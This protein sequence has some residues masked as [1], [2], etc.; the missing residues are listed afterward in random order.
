MKQDWDKYYQRNAGREP[1]K[2]L[3]EAVSFCQEKESALDLGAGMLIEARYLL[4]NGFEKVVAID[5]SVQFR[6]MS[7]K[8]A[9]KG[10]EMHAASFH[11]LRLDENKYD[12]ISAQFSLPF[13]GPAG[14]PGFVKMIIGSLKPGGIFTGQLFGTHDSWNVPG[15]NLVFH[16]K[17]QVAELLSDLQILKL[18]EVE[19]DSVTTKVKNKHWHVYH[20]IARK[21]KRH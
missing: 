10:L 13:Y 19:R 1:R 2:L 4:E 8:R 3:I 12:L 6:S 18:E 9:E 5:D 15:S 14:F 17:E 20:F 16:T 21:N 11:D 7:E